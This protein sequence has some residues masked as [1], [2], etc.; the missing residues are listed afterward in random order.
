MLKYKIDMADALKRIGFNGY[1]AK[2]TGIISQ[3]T[4]KKVKA[5]DTNISLETINRLCILLDTDIRSLIEYQEV[6][7]EREKILK[8]FLK[9]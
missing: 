9:K 3:D 5:E 8:D 4:L 2:K 6:P 1:Q 7:E